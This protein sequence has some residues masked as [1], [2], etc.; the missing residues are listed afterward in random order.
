MCDSICQSISQS[1]PVHI[2]ILQYEHTRQIS[3]FV[4]IGL[5]V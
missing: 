4:E 5:H 1:E 2:E 3:E